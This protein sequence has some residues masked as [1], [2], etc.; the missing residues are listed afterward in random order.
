MPANEKFWSVTGKLTG[1]GLVGSVPGVPW[2]ATCNTWVPFGSW[3]RHFR[4]HHQHCD[5]TLTG[6]DVPAF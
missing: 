5:R 3:P 4:N 2:Y 6:A 1:Y